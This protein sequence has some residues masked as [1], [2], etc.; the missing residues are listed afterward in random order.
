MPAIWTNPRDWT[1]KDVF[2]AAQANIQLR[3]NLLY[4]KQKPRFYV[5]LAPLANFNVAVLTATPTAI[6]DTRLLLTLTTSVA[7]EEVFIYGTFLITSPSAQGIVFDVLMDSTT[8][9]S[10]MTNTPLL[11]GIWNNSLITTGS[12][13]MI[14]FRKRVVVAAAGVHTF[15]PRI[16]MAASNQ[17]ITFISSNG[18]I[19]FGAQVE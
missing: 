15:V 4:L 13:F 19:E 10:S 3:D 12:G 11:S 18:T 9:I 7:N 5:N 8:F 1:F 14:V 17:T 2:S 6:D 16:R